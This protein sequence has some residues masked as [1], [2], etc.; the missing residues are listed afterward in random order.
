MGE[1]PAT[2]PWK[3]WNVNATPAPTLFE[4]VMSQVKLWPERSIGKFRVM[5]ECYCIIVM[6]A[7]KASP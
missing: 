3:G 4:D 7:F 1:K 2:A 6:Q 5:S